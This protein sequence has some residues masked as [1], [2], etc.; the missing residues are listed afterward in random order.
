MIAVSTVVAVVA[1]V[2][3]LLYFKRVERIFADLV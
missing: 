1:F 3:G 2:S